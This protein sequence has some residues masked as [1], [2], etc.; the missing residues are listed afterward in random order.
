MWL[1]RILMILEVGILLWMLRVDTRNSR[2]I[3]EF[4]KQRELWYA[5]RAQMKTSSKTNP[6]ATTAP[7]GAAEVNETV[8]LLKESETEQLDD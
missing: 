3:Q 5:R 7:T 8:E 6:T 2:A 4:L 1:D